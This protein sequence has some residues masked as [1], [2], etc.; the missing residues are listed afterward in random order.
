MIDFQYCREATARH[1]KL[2]LVATTTSTISVT[3][4][5]VCYVGAGTV[6]QCARKRRNIEEYG[7]GNTIVA[8]ASEK[9]E[10]LKSQ[11]SFK[12]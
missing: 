8:F 9:A 10:K 11:S 4:S 3:T 2:F 12:I 5:T 6:V 1:G 7:R